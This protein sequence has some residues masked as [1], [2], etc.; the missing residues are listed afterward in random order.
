MGY[1]KKHPKFFIGV[2]SA[3]I[4]VLLFR[5]CEQNRELRDRIDTMEVQIDAETER[6]KSNLRVLSDSVKYY[7][8]T[9]TYSK[10]VLDATEE[11]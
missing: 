2:I 1:F 4:I 10:M 9:L 5:Q 3:L 6:F 8:R 11:E 7:D